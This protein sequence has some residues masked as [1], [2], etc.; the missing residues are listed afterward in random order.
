MVH[1]S[2]INLAFGRRRSLNEVIRELETQLATNLA[3]DQRPPRI[4]DVRHSQAD[5]TVLSELFPDV[6]PFE[7]G[8]QR[9]IEWFRSRKDAS[10]ADGQQ[11]PF[12]AVPLR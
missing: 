6:T 4:G 8:L 10:S 2:A 12:A 7:R 11:P 9:T 5:G 3:R 1:P